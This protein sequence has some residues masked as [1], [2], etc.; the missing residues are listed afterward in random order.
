MV[1]KHFKDGDVSCLDGLSV[2][3]PEW[4]FNLRPSNTEPLLRLNVEADDEPLLR[5]KVQALSRLLGGPEGG[6]ES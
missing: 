1:E 2:D 5:K 4:W 3:Y 6:D